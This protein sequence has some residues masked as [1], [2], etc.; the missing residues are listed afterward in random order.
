MNKMKEWYGVVRWSPEDVIAAA[1]ELG[2]TLTTDQAVAW[3][4]Q[5][6][7][8]FQSRLVELGNEVLADMDYK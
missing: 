7:A 6:E 5:N 1:A 3:W 2:V 4:E 8:S